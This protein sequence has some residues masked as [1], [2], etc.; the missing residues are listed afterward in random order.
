MAITPAQQTEILKIFVGLF[1]AAPGSTYL[2]DSANY[3]LAGNTT[4][5]LA[6]A[7]AANTAFTGGIMAGLAT[8]AAKVMELMSHF[9]L[10]YDA[11]PVAGTADGE[12]QIWLSA[13]VNA[14]R[15]LGS[16][17]YDA[18]TYLSSAAAITSP[19]YGSAAQTL[20]NKAAV[21][22]YH[23]STLALPSGTLTSLQSVVA[24][25]TATTPIVTNADLL[26]AMSL[27][28]VSGSTFSLTTGADYLFGTSGNDTINSS[29]GAGVSTLTVADVLNGGAGTD[30]LAITSAGTAAPIMPAASVVN[31]EI[32]QITDAAA[33]P[34]TYDLL[35][36][37]DVSSVVNM[38][39]TNTVTLRNI[40]SGASLTVQGNGAT[41]NGS[42][43]FSMAA[44][45]DAITLNLAGG[46]AG[47]SP[48]NV[49]RAATGAASI[50]VNSFGA[51]NRLNLL[52]LD[53][54]TALT[55]L[56]INATTD[57]TASLGLDYAA[58][59]VLS[60]SGSA[61]TVDLSGAT[62]S[63]NFAL[64]DASGMNAGGVAV[65]LGANTTKFIGGAGNDTVAVNAL[66]YA[67]TGVTAVNVSGGNGFD[68]L[69]LTD[70][71]ALTAATSKNLVS[72]EELVFAD[73]NDNAADTFDVSL[74]A[75]V[76]TIKLNAASILDSYV[77]NNLSATQAASVTIT[78]SQETAPTL[79]VFGAATA[80]QIDTLSI[81]IND[82]LAAVNT[83]TMANLV[84]ANVEVVNF[85]ATDNFTATSLAG[86]SAVTTLTVT[87]S[88]AVN[89]T[90]GALVV[91]AGAVVN[92]SAATGS[93][94]FSGAAATANGLAIS[95]SATGANT[96]VGTSLAD[97]ITG[98]GVADAVTGGA[99]ADSI[100]LGAGADTLV[101]NSLSGAD[102]VA[103][104][105]VA[106]DGIQ[107]SRAVFT[108]LGAVGALAASE[109]ESG[110]G[111][112][113]AATAAGR[114]VYDTTAGN[115]YYDA[116]GTGVVAPVLIGTF[117][118][119]PVLVVGE[120]AIVA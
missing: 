108:G 42:T 47:V 107:F 75:G 72:F 55:G 99:G 51:A 110:A 39:S 46:L 6:Q 49:T 37:A 61:T 79:N 113:A 118:G 29:L 65:R 33:G 54:G 38:L 109:F 89:L 81:A 26:A 83:L 82:G 34:G 112:V 57:L 85:S 41:A 28:Y 102:V 101:F 119:A 63:S 116:D 5:Q 45:T 14:G 7:L 96:I 70:Q 68:S 24:G 1:N 91:K 58:G 16:V 94:T 50:T 103:D 62:L 27:A 4:A 22:A 90:T 88:G 92:A 36:V 40:V 97:T 84:A 69:R 19:V 87:G 105:V 18:V 80:G 115:L 100:T 21:A 25:V 17:V 104:Y 35:N 44:A 9:G 12:A 95:G 31:V 59:S 13:Q 98:G 74:L 60:V 73:D 53:T 67:G 111:L 15:D 76:S 71:A 56:T 64:L 120:F 2:T 48:A 32:V 8:P 30:T 43:T 20:S 114:L 10:R 86:L 23:S 93:F 117:T 52:D 78:G 77:L 11:A 106:N 3:L 66:V